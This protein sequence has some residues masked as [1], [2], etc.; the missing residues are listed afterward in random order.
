[1]TDTIDT[2][3]LPR[4]SVSDVFESLHSPEFTAAMERSS[5]ESTRLAALFDEHNVRAVDP[6]PV[7]V[8]D[9]VAADAVIVALNRVLAD[10]EVT[11]A[12]VYATVSTDY[13]DEHANALL[14]QLEVDEATV[15]PLLARLADWV[16]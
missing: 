4:W 8:A 7:T 10:T 9:G 12:A 16:N 13:R 2:E 14:S 1:M 6:R 3:Q 15:K 11:G 5:A